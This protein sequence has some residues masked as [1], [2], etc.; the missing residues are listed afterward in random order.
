MDKKDHKRTAAELH[1]RTAELITAADA[2]GD[3]FLQYLYGL[4]LRHLEEQAGV[5]NEKVELAQPVAP[6]IEE[7]AVRLKALVK[8]KGG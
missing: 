4:A 2:I 3:T 5:R 8:S 7:L 1:R 6:D